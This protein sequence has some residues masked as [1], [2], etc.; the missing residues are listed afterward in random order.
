MTGIAPLPATSQPPAVQPDAVNRDAGDREAMHKI[1]ELMAAGVRFGAI[2]EQLTVNGPGELL[3]G[4][5]AAWLQAHRDWLCAALRQTPDVFAEAE[6]PASD[7]QWAMWAAFRLQ[8]DMCAY[9]LLFGLRVPATVDIP[10]LQG[11][12]RR[13]LQRHDALRTGLC[14]VKGGLR[15]RLMPVRVEAIEVL[16]AS[17]LGAQGLLDQ[18]D[19]F[20]DRPFDLV[21]GPLLR[22]LVVQNVTALQGAALGLAAGAGECRELLFVACHHVAV[23]LWGLQLLLQDLDGLYAGAAETTPAPAYKDFC[24]WQ[25]D[26]LQSPQGRADAD[27][28]QAHWQAPLAPEPPWSA[29]GRLPSFRGQRLSRALGAERSR[30]VRALAQQFRTTPFVIL[31]S[32]FALVQSRYAGKREAIVGSPVAGRSSPHAGNTV[33]HFVNLLTLRLPVQGARVADFIEAV[34]DGWLQALGHADYP[35]PR[36]LNALLARQGS[37]ALALP[38]AVMVWH[39]ANADWLEQF[40]SSAGAL[41]RSLADVWPGSGQRG[42]AYPLILAVLD[43]GIDYRLEWTWDSALY[44]AATVQQQ[45]D[46]LEQWLETLDDLLVADPACLPLLQPS[47]L[48][49]A[50]LPNDGLPLPGDSLWQRLQHHA[51]RQPGAPAVHDVVTGA[52]LDWRSFV[53]AAGQ[54]ATALQGAGLQSGDR[55]GLW[56]ARSLTWP[57]A[58]AACWRL[59][60][61][62][63]PLDRTAPVARIAELL[64]DASISCVISDDTQAW[65]L[66]EGDSRVLHWQ[67]AGDA[68]ATTAPITAPPP[69]PMPMPLPTAAAPAYVI[70]TSGSSGRPKGVQILQR[71]LLAY[72][73]GLES[74]CRQPAASVATLAPY[75]FDASIYELS[76]ALLHG[77]ELVI[78]P[79]VLALDRDTWQTLLFTRPIDMLYIPPSLLDAL[80]ESWQASGR[81]F[82]SRFMTGVEPIAWQTLQAW[83]ACRPD[84]DILNQYGPTETTIAVTTCAVTPLAA[85]RRQAVADPQ[86]R[87]PLG[88][89]S[90]GVRIELQDTCGRVVPRGEPGEAVVFG[91]LVGA[92]YIGHAA[93][94][95]HRFGENSQGERHY[96]TGDWMRV[97][98]GQLVYLGR[99]DQQV[100]LRGVRIELGEVRA[101]LLRLPGVQSAWVETRTHASGT[102][103]LVAHVASE[104]STYEQSTYEQSASALQA[105]LRQQLPPLLQPAY[106]ITHTSL[107]LNR[108]GKVDAA[109]LAATPLPVAEADARSPHGAAEQAVWEA[110]CAELPE[111]PQHVHDNFFARGGHSL[112]AARIA[113]RLLAAGYAVNVTQLL[114][115]LDIASQAALLV[116][117]VSARTALLPRDTRGRVAI[118]GPVLPFQFT[119]WAH[120]ALQ[121]PSTAYTVPL[122]LCFPQALPH[123]SLIHYWQDALLR[124]EALRTGFVDAGL[125]LQ[126]Q[127]FNQVTLPLC[128]EQVSLA[129]PDALDATLQALIAERVQVPLVLAAGAPLW[130]V[131]CIDITLGDGAARV[132]STSSAEAPVASSH[133]L[134]LALFH[135]A[136]FDGSSVRALFE[137]WQPRHAAQPV[138]GMVDAVQ[139]ILQQ[140]LP[141]ANDGLA[142]W[143]RELAGCELH[144][145]PRRL[146]PPAVFPAGKPV[147]VESRRLTPA[148]LANLQQVARQLGC[149]PFHIAL[150]LYQL[151]LAR[152]SQHVQGAVAVPVDLRE[153][154]Y[155]DVVGGLVNTLAI[156]CRFDWD[157]TLADAIRTTQTFLNRC[158]PYRAVPLDQIVQALGGP[159]RQW[160]D[161]LFGSIFVW[162]EA[163]GAEPPAG[164]R[165]LRAEPQQPKTDLEFVL[166]ADSVRLLWRSERF[167]AVTMTSLIDAYCHLLS[168]LPTSL[169]QPVGQLPLMSSDHWQAQVQALSGDTAFTPLTAHVLDY[170]LARANARPEAVAI[171]H[172]DR[173]LDYAGLLQQVRLYAAGLV[174]QG[175]VAGDHVAFALPRTPETVAVLLAIWW[176]GAAYVPL[177]LRW[178]EE[179]QLQ[180]LAASGA[181]TVL[182]ES[183]QCDG[184][185]AHGPAN[186]LTLADLTLTDLTLAD[187]TLADLALA[188]PGTPHITS[189][190]QTAYVLFTSGSTGLPKG[191]VISHGNLAAF[192]RWI[193]DFYPT[194]DFRGLLAVTTFAF[195]ISV[196]E[197]F[198]TL[199]SGGTI[200]LGDDPLALL[201]PQVREA[202]AGK[203]SFLC[204]VPSAA[205]AWLDAQVIP[206]GI[207]T[208]NMGGEFLPQALVERLYQA[209]VGRVLDL[210]GPTEDTTYSMVALRTAGGVPHIG[211]PIR[212][213]RMWVLDARQQPVPR[214]VKGELILG[215]FGLSKGYLNAPALTDKVFIANPLPAFAGEVP[216][217]YRSGDIGWQDAEDNLHYS[218]RADFQVKLRGQRLEPGEIEACLRRHPEVRAA[219]VLLCQPDDQP[220]CLLACVE[221]QPPQTLDIDALAGFVAQALPAYM[222]P[223]R[224]L[225]VTDWPLNAN[226]KV[227]RKQLQ[228]RAAEAVSLALADAADG[229]PANALEARLLEACA[230]V[231]PER[232]VPLTRPLDQLGLDSIM[233]LRLSF[234]IQSRL[235]LAQ[236]IPLSVWLQQRTLR[237]VGE[238]L[239]QKVTLGTWTRLNDAPVTAPVIACV[240]AVGGEITGFQALARQLAPAWQVWA[241][242]LPEDAHREV[243]L[244]TLAARYAAAW[245]EVGAETV[246][247]AGYSLGGLIAAHMLAPLQ[248]QGVTVE[249]LLLLDS[250]T[251]EALSAHPMIR[252]FPKAA[253]QADAD[254]ANLYALAAQ[255][256]WLPAD[257]PLARVRQRLDSIAHLLRIALPDRLPAIHVPVVHV[258]STLDQTAARTHW[259][260]YLQAPVVWRETDAWH[261]AVL[262]DEFLS[263]VVHALQCA[264][265]PLT[266]VVSTSIREECIP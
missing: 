66:I 142:F 141:L 54:L 86:A 212:D 16:D 119:L 254:W 180:V 107:P 25:Q 234:A 189:W 32:L 87:V 168:E 224:W 150:T 171:R 2:G 123:Q 5:T 220:A 4:A 92:G 221:A 80:R 34:R 96:R 159:A 50:C 124:H 179:R 30:R 65:P 47:V 264:I 115:H 245:H 233:M 155:R 256:G 10:R 156:P 214:G 138:P 82:P 218:A 185:L 201:N 99:A 112:I 11:A 250:F 101:A 182:L 6:W 43:R 109:T 130:R 198:G 259:P 45:A 169:D 206:A 147:Q 52:T 139:A 90:P 94:A 127:V 227:D 262:D 110:W 164:V 200:C 202:Y 76:S 84:M 108:H 39:Q 56:L 243:S 216:R 226:G 57:V 71:N 203:L 9:N 117:T 260:R 63:V 266:S 105:A 79:E 23:D 152:F 161:V 46:D 255:A 37:T 85:D 184:A 170:L 103:Y 174:G 247:L 167:E 41:L 125:Q 166:S 215:G 183:A 116:P 53:D 88:Q 207:R 222:V 196:F 162:E 114:Q 229:G 73:D 60:V 42:A 3:S 48:T 175:V 33:G 244:S 111:P 195:D 19:A 231:L 265:P 44:D 149:S 12:L 242:A 177:D 102:P 144:D 55:V 204:S 187:P 197:L 145:L 191:V 140:H 157:S 240:H 176:V 8:P 7:A 246:V 118:T 36:V 158:Q 235:A 181:R 70:Y 192:M 165:W 29:A 120:E 31:L 26:Y 193:Q 248:Q 122:A 77:R 38:P 68:L 257:L 98:A 258:A 217:V 75:T 239:A 134:V 263:P 35:F 190:E 28:W 232:V 163:D 58:C 126:Q 151:V 143:Q 210:W 106:L 72:S 51:D 83:L 64:Q 69:P 49:G 252:H 228:L 27:F 131:H 40:F 225:A 199:C 146:A 223:A 172:L 261:G 17:Q 21:N 211:K 213:T 59:G 136:I 81:R 154:G 188:D 62:F 241:V 128:F 160:L 219:M 78:L 22:L 148:V 230:E 67:V 178:P 153:A 74:Q 132:D 205:V 135:H 91:A 251:P 137:S 20:G 173:E 93:T 13:L 18:V 104:Q 113:S 249:R 24:D 61:A 236:P 97:E 186:A 129:S 15:A 14:E 133:T 253:A 100:K 209:G 237:G 194:E 95:D 208:V 89:P 1:R 121:G 238:Y